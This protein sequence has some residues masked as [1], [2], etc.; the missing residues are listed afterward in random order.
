[1]MNKRY[2]TLPNF[3][4][5]RVPD[6]EVLKYLKN[7]KR[8]CA[9]GLDNTPACYLKDAAYVIAKPLS[10]M[11]NISLASGIVPNNLKNARV[12]PIFKS[13]DAHNFENYRPINILPVIS[14]LFEKSQSDDEISRIQQ[15]VSTEPV[16]LSK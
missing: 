14:K 4:F 10:H 8:K 15:H 2:S 1:M 3:A 12:T 13:G 5:K 6:T 11:I 16:W 7:L 9:T